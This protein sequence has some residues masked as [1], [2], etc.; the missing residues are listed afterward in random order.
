MKYIRFEYAGFVIFEEDQKH[1]DIALKFPNDTILSAGFVKI[2]FEEDQ[3]GVYGESAS[4][5]KACNPDDGKAL[6]H[7]LSYGY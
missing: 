4:L 5:S 1:S 6:Y 2:A 3:I 7:K